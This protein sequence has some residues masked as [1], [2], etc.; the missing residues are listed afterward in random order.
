MF[1]G[2]KENDLMAEVE[3]ILESDRQEAINLQTV[4]DG[5][6]SIGIELAS[7]GFKSSKDILKSKAVKKS[8]KVAS[9]IISAYFPKAAGGLSKV[10][11]VGKIA[12]GAASKVLGVL[13]IPFEIVNI[14]REAKFIPG[15]CD[16]S[17]QLR[18]LI[19]ELEQDL[20]EKRQ[21]LE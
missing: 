10:L 7:M 12:K 17:R 4:L 3:S 14:V 13:T 5:L 15:G 18:Q 20:Q 21:L 19:E 9:K 8:S 2:S 6:Q 1:K 11:G 16:E